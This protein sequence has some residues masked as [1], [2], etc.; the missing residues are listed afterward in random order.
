MRKWLSSSVAAN[1]VAIAALLVA[2]WAAKDANRASRDTRAIAI[3][4]KK[5]QALVSLVTVRD[6][7]IPFQKSAEDFLE[8]REFNILSSDAISIGEQI[9]KTK[10]IIVRLGEVEKDLERFS[11]STRTVEIAD[12]Y[13]RFEQIRAEAAT[14]DKSFEAS[15]REIVSRALKAK[16]K[17]PNTA[18]QS[19]PHL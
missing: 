7:M 3:Y 17:Q 2:A 16:E 18:P 1:F 12:A 5:A 10:S 15:K 14:L 11:D 4:E 8:E 13:A 19:T 6:Q 9:A